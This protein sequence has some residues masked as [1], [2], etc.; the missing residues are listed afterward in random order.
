MIEVE[1]PDGSIAEFPQGTD[2]ETIKSALQKRFPAKQAQWSD[3]PGNILPSA[4][5]MAGDIWQAASHPLQTV[6]ALNDAAM[7]GVERLKPQWLAD[8]HKQMPWAP[9]KET[10]DRQ[11]QVSGVMGEALKNRYGSLDNIRNTAITDPVGFLGDASMVATGGGSAVARLPVAGAQ[12]MGRMAA[13]A[14]TLIDP[15]MMAGKGLKTAGKGVGIA[16][17]YPLG[18]TSGAAPEA[19]Q[20]AAKAGFEGGDAASAFRGNMRGSEAPENVIADAQGALG[21]MAE[22][23]RADYLANMAETNASQ[24]QVDTAPIRQTLADLNQSLRVALPNVPVG[25]GQPLSNSAAF[26]ALEKGTPAE[27]AKLAE[28]EKLLSTWE[29]H[30]QGTTPIAMDALKQRV[31][32]MQ[33]SFTDPNAANERRLVTAMGDAIKSGITEQVPSY[34]KAMDEYASAMDLK[35]DIEK[36]LGV[37]PTYSP[38]TAISKLQSTLTNQRRAKLAEALQENGASHLKSRIAGQQLNS[39]MPKGGMGKLVAALTGSASFWNPALAPALVASSPRAIGE[40]AHAL[41]RGTR[42]IQQHGNSKAAILAAMLG[43]QPQEQSQ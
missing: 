42:R 23:R 11:E 6:N 35:T 29:A 24:A 16:A 25:N 39:I 28:M 20:T 43:R 40:I 32:R 36:S 12:T 15:V 30:P 41:G 2:Q 13:T 5:K 21:N 3:L 1:L 14:G 33:P 8:I 27:F 38:D 7:G 34:G 37:G 4:G 9:S 26:P 17:S 31:Q 19:I 18:L 22:K 10:L